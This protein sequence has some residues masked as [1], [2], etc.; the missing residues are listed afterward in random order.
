MT[1]PSHEKTVL[2]SHQNAATSLIQD[3]KT[4]VGAVTDASLSEGTS[5]SYAVLVKNLDGDITI[6]PSQTV[7]TPVSPPVSSLIA[8]WKFDNSPA[9]A[10]GNIRSL[11]EHNTPTYSTSVV[12]F[13]THSIYFNGLNQYVSSAYQFNNV[14]NFALAGWFHVAPTPD[15]TTD[16]VSF[17]GQND[18]IEMGLRLNSG[19]MKLCLWVAGTSDACTALISKAMWMKLRFGIVS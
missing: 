11:T 10:S 17:F 15:N 8:H 6:Y 1:N 9:D 13:G 3:W 12:K 14:S 16:R 2:D 4:A 18:L 5:Y 19:E 7:K